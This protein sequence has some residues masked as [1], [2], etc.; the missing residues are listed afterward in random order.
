MPIELTSV[1]L[2]GSNSLG[3][4]FPVYVTHDG[5]QIALKFRGVGP[6]SLFL[7]VRK[8]D[9]PAYRSAIGKFIEWDDLAHSRGDMFTKKI[10]H[11]DYMSGAI[12]L[13][14]FQSASLNNN[15]I[16]FGV[17]SRL[18]GEGTAVAEDLRLDRLNAQRLDTLLSDYAANRLPSKDG[19]NNYR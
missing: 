17:R 2:P 4:T 3:G 8:R 10:S 13:V 12:I 5:D 18:L 14:M 7:T 1:Q 9:V 16:C 15:L 6:Q 11:F 19:S